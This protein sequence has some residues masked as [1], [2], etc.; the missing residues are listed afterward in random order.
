[1]HSLFTNMFL[2]GSWM[3]LI[4]NM[5]FLWVFGDNIEARMGNIKFLLFYICGGLAASGAHILLNIGSNIPAV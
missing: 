4:G 1:M 3:H 5:L 2:H